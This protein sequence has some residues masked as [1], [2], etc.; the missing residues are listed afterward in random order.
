MSLVF[1]AKKF[2]NIPPPMPAMPHSI[3]EKIFELIIKHYD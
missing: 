2:L 3:E 1:F